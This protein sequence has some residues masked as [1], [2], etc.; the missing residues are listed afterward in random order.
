LISTFSTCT[1]LLVSLLA[2]L[3]TSLLFVF[4]RHQTRQ[5]ARHDFVSTTGLG[6][7]AG[8]TTI[9][10]GDIGSSAMRS[11]RKQ[12]DRSRLVR[13][14]SI[15]YVAANINNF[16]WLIIFNR[17][18]LNSL[19][20]EDIHGR[21][22]IIFASGILLFLFMPMYGFFNFCIYC[23]PR[24]RRIKGH[25]PEKSFWW[26][27]RQLYTTDQGESEITQQ[28]LLKRLRQSRENLLE[29]SLGAIS[30]SGTLEPPE[31]LQQQDISKSNKESIEKH[32]F[33]HSG[34]T[35]L[36]L[37][38]DDEEEDIENDDDHLTT[39]PTS[40]IEKL[41]ST[42]CDTSQV[43]HDEEMQM[44]LADNSENKKLYVDH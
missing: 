27:L 30:F 40:D 9:A 31:K 38:F 32:Q 19:H 14:Q 26:C 41:P 37:S 3:C 24:F 36:V 17:L 43:L 29:S 20:T 16:L 5:S 6:S 11:N 10:T 25:F 21:D 18:V 4:V 7:T 22:S 39:N 1:T 44:D 13:T 12:D 42:T 8:I 34:D 23:Y 15:L 2:I 33:H 35:A 28:R